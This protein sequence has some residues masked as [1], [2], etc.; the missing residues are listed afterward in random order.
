MAFWKLQ[1]FDRH[2]FYLINGGIGL[3]K[4]DLQ[5]RKIHHADSLVACGKILSLLTLKLN[6][7]TPKRP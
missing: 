7:L 2:G 4:R 3:T 5:I 1:T 6:P